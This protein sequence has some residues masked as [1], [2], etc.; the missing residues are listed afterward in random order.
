[1]KR[2]LLTLSLLLVIISGAAFSEEDKTVALVNRVIRTV[3]L[4]SGEEDWKDAKP[5]APLIDKDEIRTGEN[6]LAIVSFLDGSLLRVRSSSVVVI[7]GDKKNKSLDKNVIIDKGVIGFDVKKQNDETFKFTTPALVASI[8][9]TSG[10]I[11]VN[12]NG[13]TLFALE[14]GEV[15][16]E[17]S[18]GEKQSAVIT[19]GNGVRVG[20]DGVVTVV[21]NDDEVNKKINS[22]SRSTIKTIKIETDEGIIEIE[23][24]SDEK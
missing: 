23:Y 10:I 22:A 24:Y 2:V 18:S 12:E 3:E 20:S 4:K 13:E 11:E 6:S 15:E 1:M 21:E 9:G 14:T 8:R 19:P 7:Y 5:G 17:A 16:I